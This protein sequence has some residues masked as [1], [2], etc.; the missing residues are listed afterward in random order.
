M[1]KWLSGGRP[2]ADLSE[3]D[4]GAI[5]VTANSIM[6]TTYLVAGLLAPFLGAAIDRVGLRAALTLASSVLIVA[7]HVCLAFTDV[8]PVVPLVILGICYSVY[9]SALWPSVALVTEPAY[10]ATAY[11]VVTAVQN[12]GLAVVPLG[13][14]SLMPAPACRP[15]ASCVAAY[16]RVELLLIGFGLVGILAAAALNV[17]DTASEIRVL[18]WPEKRVAAA[19]AAAAAKMGGMGAGAKAAAE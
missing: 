12:F 3:S 16:Q 11:G 7:V 9:A 14:G 5:S 2:L 8:Y 15:F 4:R 6:L 19:R 13:V 1:Q 10:H 17:A 18:N